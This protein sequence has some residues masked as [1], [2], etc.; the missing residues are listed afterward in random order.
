M[1]KEIQ[2]LMDDGVS[3]M[4]VTVANENGALRVNFIPK[5]SGECDLT[6][7]P[8]SLLGTADDLDA[9]F[10]E[11]IRSY[12]GTRKS[13]ADQVAQSNAEAEALAKEASEKARAKASAKPVKLASNSAPAETVVSPAPKAKPEPK[14]AADIGTLF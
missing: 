4:T 6:A 3:F 11:A 10:I 7:T 2:Q 1:F 5:A 14:V 9:G 12:R 13:I 8:L